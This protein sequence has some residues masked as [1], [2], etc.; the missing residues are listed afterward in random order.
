M[1]LSSFAAGLFLGGNKIWRLER[2]YVG[3]KGRNGV[4]RNTVF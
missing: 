3:Q 2:L 1:S 4:G